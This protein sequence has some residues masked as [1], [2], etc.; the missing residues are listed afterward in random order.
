MKRFAALYAGLDGTTKTA[1]KITAMASYF[2]EVHPADGAWAVYLLSGRKIPQ[3]IAT[4]K[5]G[6]WAAEMADVPDWLFAECYDA[7]GD[8]AETISLLLPEPTAGYDDT[9]STWIEQRLEHLRGLSDLLQRSE[10]R[11]AWLELTPTERLV[12][13]KIITGSFRVGVSQRLVVRA[14]SAAWQLPADVLEHRLMGSWKPTAEFFQQLRSPRLDDAQRGRPYPFLLAHPLTQPPDGLGAIGDWQLEWKWDGIRAQLLR[15]ANECYLWSRGEELITDR[16]PEIAAA[17][18]R[19]PDGVAVDGEIVAWSQGQVL[20]FA[21]L[22][23]RIGRQHLTRK[24]LTEAPVALLAFDVLEWQGADW[25]GRPLCERR[26]CLEELLSTLSHPALEIAPLV[27]ARSWSEAVGRRAES[28]ARLAEGLM[29]KRKHSAYGVGRPRGDW[30]K[31][32]IDPYTVDAVLVYAQKGSGK[33]ASLFTDYT[34]AVWDGTE[35]VPFAKAYSGLN[36]E[37]IREVDQFIRQ[38]TLSRHGP[39]RTVEPQ[40]VFELAFEGLRVSRRHRSGIAVRFP[41]IA[42]WRRD[43]RPAEADSLE[44][45]RSFLPA[46]RRAVP[47]DPPGTRYLWDEPR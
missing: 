5:L 30:W 26:Q 43:K 25:R 34:F 23:R 21:L 22:Q 10:L 32:K 18:E 19:L 38:H 45:L 24:V 35:L 16:F 20:P 27:A 14:L 36:D 12:L 39:V 4:R 31:W 42:R 40:L 29:I 7:V 33:R 13:N 41:R 17:A 8:L 28:R 11:R 3:F 15:R 1:E 9:L 46:D 6:R 44:Q 2:C 47:R 37:E